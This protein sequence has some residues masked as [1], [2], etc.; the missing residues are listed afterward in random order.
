MDRELHEKLLLRNEQTKQVRL[1]EVYIDHEEA[2]KN[3]TTWMS[4]QYIT[5]A[6]DKIIYVGGYFDP[7]GTESGMLTQ[8]HRSRTN[9]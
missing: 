5:D 4:A 6:R 2:K 3:V 8:Q 1:P 7:I 9:G